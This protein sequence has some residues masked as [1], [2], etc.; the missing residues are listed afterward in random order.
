M[1]A[2]SVLP[3]W[4]PPP[5]SH[6][7]PPRRRPGPGG[8]PAA[9]GAQRLAGGLRDGGGWRSHVGGAGVSGGGEGGAT[10]A[11]AVAAAG[12]AA[13]A[14]AGR[15]PR[16]R[17]AQQALVAHPAAGDG[18]AGGRLVVALAQCWV[19]LRQGRQ[20]PAGSMQHAHTA[21]RN[22]ACAA[23]PSARCSRWG[24]QQLLSPLVGGG[25]LTSAPECDSQASYSCTTEQ[26]YTPAGAPARSRARRLL[27]CAGCTALS[28]GAFSRCKRGCRSSSA[29]WAWTAWRGRVG[30]GASVRG[31]APAWCLPSG[32]EALGGWGR[33]TQLSY[34]A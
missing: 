25:S 11:A 23:R 3:A 17:R 20:L 30:A 33:A 34:H 29:A 26:C 12:A 10:P 7:P 24:V 18:S 27:R 9:G 2:A 16:W 22:A 31:G 8:C 14:A 19:V 28:A 6:P 1:T 32:N 4:A 13:A 5:P 15:L 21:K